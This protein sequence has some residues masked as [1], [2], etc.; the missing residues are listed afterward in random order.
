MCQRESGDSAAVYGQLPF[1][2][3]VLAASP[4]LASRGYGVGSTC[5]GQADPVAFRSIGL[6][7][8]PRWQRSSATVVRGRS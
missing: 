4:S 1:G 2:V 8:G 7:G 5:A 6:S 3:G